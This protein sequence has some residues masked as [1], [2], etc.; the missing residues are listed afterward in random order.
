M[1]KNPYLGK[2]FDGQ[3]WALGQNR[4]VRDKMIHG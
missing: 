2:V 3:T 4:P 1:D